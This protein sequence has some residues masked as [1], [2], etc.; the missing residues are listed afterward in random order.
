MEAVFL[1]LFNM[2][3]TAGWLILTVIALRVALKKAPKWIICLLWGMVA[4]RLICPVSPE[5]IFS[6]IPSREI[7]RHET[8][9]SES[10][11]IDS[12]IRLV[13]NVVNP[14]L[15][16][17]FTPE[18]GA[19]VNPLQVWLSA[20]GILW[21]AGMGAMLVYAAVS[22]V[23]LR[24]RIRAA[25]RLEEPV[26][27]SE[28]VDTPFVFGVFRPRIYLPSGMQEAMRAPV[29]A[30]EKAHLARRDHLW[31]ILG[32]VLLAVYW[33]HPLCWAAYVLFCRDI[34][35]ACDEKVIRNYDARQKKEY[36]EALLACSLR[37]HAV[38]ACPL[39]FG[40]VGVKDRIRS[41]VN[42]KKPAFWV[43][44]A[45][46][47]SCI[48]AALCF[49][50][51]P[52]GDRRKSGEADVTG[53]EESRTSGD[54]K[55]EVSDPGSGSSAGNGD[56]GLSDVGAEEEGNSL[57]SGQISGEETDGENNLLTAFIG[58]WTEAFVSR[59]GTEIAELATSE[60]IV[61]MK[62]NEL[63]SG[64]EGRYSFRES[65]SWPGNPETDVLVRSMD[66][67]KAEII[68][69]ARSSD[70][71]VTVWKE[72]LFYELREGKYVIT[73]EELIWYDNISS[74]AEFAEAYDVSAA[75]DGSGIYY[76]GIDG[77]GMDYSSNGTGEELNREALLSS[78]LEYRALFEPESAAV[79]LLNLSEDAVEVQVQ[80][81]MR[82]GDAVERSGKIDIAGG[83]DLADLEIAFSEERA[84]VKIS[85]VRYGS[86]GIWV[87]VNYRVYPL[88]RFMELDWD[89]VRSKNLS[90]NKDPDWSDIVCIGEIP[91]KKIKLYGYNDQ[92]CSDMGVAIEFGDDV[93]YFDWIYTSRH[94]LTPE[95]YPECYWDESSRLLQVALNI[96]TGVGADAQELHVLQHYDTGTLQDN[97]FDAK[98]YEEL[99]GQRID[100]SYD[101]ETGKLTLLDSKKGQELAVVELSVEEL[102]G[103]SVGSLELGSISRF[104]LGDEIIF[105]VKPGFC[106]EGSHMAEYDGMPTL[107]MELS[108]LWNDSGTLTFDFG[109]IRIAGRRL[110]L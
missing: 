78:S 103:S 82:S 94:W 97:T 68:Y 4:V 64:S 43:I 16:E 77:T 47:A 87:P 21:A 20:A 32:Y 2:S 56:T 28:F 51:N 62:E 71:L 26:Y 73:S 13:D 15:Q 92:E 30:H 109:D 23:L 18:P 110:W 50:T 52:V 42:Y 25:V 76:V 29:I 67:E 84:S 58:K 86:I 40:E 59:N 12:G 100:F 72:I 69:Y 54:S 90:L 75:I 55:A 102:Q 60:A 74:M 24:L 6:L 107:E 101:G 9:L 27:I 33:F 105:L 65:D 1:K 61:Q 106:R 17:S 44:V 79:M 95:C 46:V 57:H 31:K 81:T 38:T 80:R 108:I 99:L 70:Y 49:L 3:I 41:V 104:I 34:E 98:A 35:L 85:M 96:Y 93:N 36:S 5:S 91:E 7:I 88:Y 14:V 53:P 39:A 45:A 83:G 48:V 8:V 22:Y 37:H 19:S 66:G 11:S 10:P 63:V 89:E